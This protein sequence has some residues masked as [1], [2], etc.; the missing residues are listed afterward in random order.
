MGQKRACD[1]CHKRKIHC[2]APIADAQCNWCD[3]HSLTC[4]F[5]R[6]R[7]KRKLQKA[8]PSLGSEKKLV[9][10]LE[11]L[12]NA[13]ARVIGLGNSIDPSSSSAAGSTMTPP[14]MKAQAPDECFASLGE[15]FAAYESNHPLYIESPSALSTSNISNGQI[16]LAGCPLGHITCHNGM[17][18]FSEE[19]QA[20]IFSRT[21]EATTFQKLKAFNKHQQVQPPTLSLLHLRGS[22]EQRYE[23]PDRSIVEQGIYWFQNSAFRLVFPA[24]DTVLFQDSVNL[25]Y[26]PWEGPLS[27]ERISAKGC[28][29]AFLAIMCVFNGDSTWRPIVDSDAC[30]IKAHYLL[31]NMVE[32]ASIVTLQTVFMLHMHQIFSGRLQSAAMLHAVACRIIFMLGGHTQTNFKPYGAEITR[33]QREIRHLRMIFWLCYIFDQDTALRTG[34]PPIMCQEHCDLTLPD[35]YLENCFCLPA[36]S[37]DI[38]SP[39]FADESLFPYLPGDLRLGQL[40]GKAFRLLYSVQAL[41]KSD[42]ELLRDIRELDNEIETWRLSIPLKFRPALSISQHP[43]LVPEIKLPQSMQHIALRLEYH[44]LMA[45]IHR[46]SGRC[47]PI[48]PDASFHEGERSSAIDSSLA[49]ALEASR[50]TLYYLQA[51]IDGLA[52]E[53]FW[54]IVFYPTA[55]IMTLFFNVLLNPLDTQANLDLGLLSSAADLIRSM[56]IR[57][58]TRYEIE[59]LKMVDDFIAELIRLG[60]C[61][62]SKAKG[63]EE[64]EGETRVPRGHELGHEIRIL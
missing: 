26:E 38:V 5:N 46:A 18:L 11:R 59:H 25:A 12:E 44:H 6:V 23:L 61:A 48:S 39:S 1:A 30:A 51:A 10:R 43:R 57:R 21:G 35:G 14:S 19:G 4:T 54:I 63:E 20:W 33:K 3:H 8:K 62:I 24:I 2:D 49:L 13:L 15:Q 17:P 31:S 34:Q 60:N 41:G 29:L 50:S 53:A 42:A 16:H 7:G 40:K 55:A 56:P 52:G 9:E 64:R 37:N 27:L 32:D 58:L 45:T 47:Y 28:V 36:L 22:L